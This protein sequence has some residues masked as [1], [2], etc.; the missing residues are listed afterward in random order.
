M[1][2]IC[3]IRIEAY[4][5]VLFDFDGLLVDT[6]PLHYKA[7][8]ALCAGD[9]VELGWD[10]KT[11]C[12]IAHESSSGLKNAIYPL[13]AKTGVSWEE[14]YL[15][16]QNKLSA[17]LKSSDILLMPGAEDLLLC[18]K[19]AGITA[20]VVTNSKR[21]D[22]D[23]IRAK[24]SA[25]Q[26]ISHW[27]TREDYQHGKPHPESYLTAIERYGQNAHHIIGF[28]DSFRGYSALSQTRAEA[29]LVCPSSHPQ[30]RKIDTS[31]VH[32]Y[33]SLQ[34]FNRAL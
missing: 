25:L 2:Y 7:Y 11:F 9:G 24:I 8:L 10:F 33:E 23:I 26:T 30:M 1:Y 6:E 28:E 31:E 19:K 14:K 29:V 3:M 15:E 34:D 21:S 20:C 18:I 16:K 13:L 32:H 17:F 22:I 5:L 12:Q 4:D 27:I